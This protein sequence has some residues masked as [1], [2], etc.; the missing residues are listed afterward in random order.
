MAD[1][2]YHKVGTTFRTS[3]VYLDSTGVA[4]TGLVAGNFT[5]ELVK[6]GVGNQAS[7][8]ITIAEIDATHNAGEYSITVSGVTGFASATGEYELVVYLTA[9]PS[10][11]WSISVRVTSDGTGNGT[12]G[13][14]SFTAVASNGR[15]MSGGSPLSGA[16]V[17][18]V[19]SA[20]VL[21][22][23]TTSDASGL[24]GPVYFNTN[25]TYTAYVQKSSYTTTSGTITVTGL[26]TATG[27]LTDLSITASS[28]GSSITA[29]SLWSY[30]RRQYG[31]RNGTK[32]DTEIQQITDDAVWMI[33]NRRHWPWLHTA[34]RIAF[35]AS[36]NTGSIAVTNGSAV[37]TLTSGTWPTWAASGEVC[38]N[39]LWQT[40]L[41][42]DS[43]TRLTLV[44][45]W[46]E[47]TASGLSYVIAQHSYSLPS[48][49]QSIEE[50]LA[51][52]SW[53]W[54]PDPVSA[55]TLEIQRTIIPTGMNCP[56]LFAIRKDQLLVWP[57]PSGDKM[58]NLTY[59]RRPASMV[60]SSDTMDFDPLLLELVRRAIDYQVAI[61]GE[62]VAGSRSE[63]LKSF[64]DALASAAPN[65]RTPEN[66]NL[67]RFDPFAAPG[68]ANIF[69]NSISG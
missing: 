66:R 52:S 45:A 24:W 15:V 6:D 58:V 9:T 44:N 40:I 2:P 20:G 27:P 14:V 46:G 5:I 12:W 41:T 59:F 8:G 54:G 28:A 10:A 53:P 65:D 7:T 4:V 69:A 26:T 22:V 31:D 16:T 42:R 25:G 3:F 60:N 18:I 11:R 48:D 23:Q 61:R 68:V 36:Y 55:A 1:G 29:G 64:E 32:A 13:A 43:G 21:Y 34:G 67:V 63:C 39:G 47:A 30:A 35:H 56:S 33:C 49:C 19:D 50:I 62:C 51:G 37:V 17:R 38:I 57:Y